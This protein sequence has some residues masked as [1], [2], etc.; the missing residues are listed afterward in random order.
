M[1]IARAID[2]SKQLVN[3]H[4]SCHGLLPSS[5][6]DGIDF[7]QRRSAPTRA[8]QRASAQRRT[9]M[10]FAHISTHYGMRE[11]MIRDKMKRTLHKVSDPGVFRTQITAQCSHQ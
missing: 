8:E 4:G 1:L 9:L 7:E 2:L 5:F 11:S 3:F 6:F 10:I